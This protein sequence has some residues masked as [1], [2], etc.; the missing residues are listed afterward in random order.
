[1]CGSVDARFPR[2]ALSVSFASQVVNKIWKAAAAVGHGD[3]FLSDTRHFVGIDDHLIVNEGTG[4]PVADIIAF[5]DATQA[6]PSS[7]HTHADN[8][9][10]IDKATLEAV[11]TTMMQVVWSER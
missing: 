11:G 2:E 4:I 1:M 10:G 6:F 5:D 7:W 8:M 3:R 9:S